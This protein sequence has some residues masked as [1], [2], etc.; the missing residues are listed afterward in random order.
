MATRLGPNLVYTNSP[1][2]RPLTDRDLFIV[3]EYVRV[4]S[5]N[6]GGTWFYTYN[7][8]VDHPYFAPRSGFVRA[9][10]KYQGMVGVSGGGG[11]TRLTWMVNVDFG[12]SVPSSF[13]NA[14]IV[15]L[16]VF[17]VAV[18][19]RTKRYLR[20]KES[21]VAAAV[22]SSPVLDDLTS[23]AAKSKGADVDVE[24][25]LPD[26]TAKL[27]EM[28]AEMER[29]N[30]EWRRKDEEHQKELATNYEELRRKDEKHQNDLASKDELAEMKAEMARKE[31]E[32]RKK[33]E[34]LQM[35]LAEKDEELKTKEA[36]IQELRRRLPRS[37]VDSDK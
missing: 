32:S 12:G 13:M 3:Q 31:E 20:Q 36:E 5:G 21:N 8:D 25:E 19:E 24:L 2:H 33:E 14:I 9:M 6:D 10:M 4:T 17:P 7:H 23:A 22:T 30:E 28:K 29:K 37:S 27:A 11:K 18:V 1:Y 15:N 16:M 35:V 26:L 34:E